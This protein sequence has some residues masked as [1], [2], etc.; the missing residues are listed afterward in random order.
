MNEKKK[1]HRDLS[2]N[3]K[4]NK[5]EKNSYHS[6]LSSKKSEKD[7]NKTIKKIIN[8][9]RNNKYKKTEIINKVKF[10][11]DI[12][13]INA[14][15][16]NNNEEIKKKKRFKTTRNLSIKKKK[17]RNKDK[18]KEEKFI[19]NKGLLKVQNPI[20][21][22]ELPKQKYSCFIKNKNNEINNKEIK[23][24]L[25]HREE[26]F[27]IEINN[28]LSID[29]LIEQI[30]Q[31]IKIIKNELELFLIYDIK[32]YLN[33]Y[34]NLNYFFKNCSIKG[35]EKENKIKKS[36]NELKFLEK[37]NYN[38]KNDIKRKLLIYPDIDNKFKNIKIRELLKD[39]YNYYIKANQVS[40]NKYNS[41]FYYRNEI[42]NLNI[43]SFDSNINNEIEK[44]NLL[45]SKNNIKTLD[46]KKSYEGNEGGIDIKKKY[47]N[48]VIVEGVSLLSDFFNEIKSF[49]VEHEIKDNYNFQNAGIDKYI[50]GFQR[51]DIAY[52]FNKFVN[53]LQLTNPKYFHIR[54]KLKIFDLQNNILHNSIEK[55][56][57]IKN[58]FFFPSKFNNNNV[59]T[60]KK[61]LKGKSNC[62]FLNKGEKKFILNDN[63]VESMNEIIMMNKYKFIQN[64]NKM[65]YIDNENYLT[66]PLI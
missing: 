14:K 1:T 25:F 62:Y 64:K 9:S 5:E 60:L 26:I 20:I 53:L 58:K 33:S 47:K 56:H 66:I 51:K 22:D 48:K 50:F 6:S 21:V 57:N 38:I 39:K 13:N 30:L 46:I 8:N 3:L 16:P 17:E 45:L 24:Y 2:L 37:N 12:S 65:N 27:F 44:N 23:I 63:D 35:F 10:K 40:K 11:E 29:N 4:N 32:P 54:S 52:D 41:N 28:G 18:D 15:S 36:I 61:N 42:K 59:F 49:M 19:I 55:S 34:K 7:E 31:K 43:N